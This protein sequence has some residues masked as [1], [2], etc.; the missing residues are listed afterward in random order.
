MGSRFT[1][2]AEVIAFGVS[3]QVLCSRKESPNP[4]K[5]LL[6]KYRPDK[7]PKLIRDYCA[8]IPSLAKGIT[9]RLNCIMVGEGFGKMVFFILLTC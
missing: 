2:S 5:M 3:G 1:S 7:D 6:A 9:N 4:Y 8:R